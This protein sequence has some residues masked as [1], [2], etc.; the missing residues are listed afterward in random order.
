MA[1]EAPAAG[2]LSIV[3]RKQGFHQGV[4]PLPSPQP[5]PSGLPSPTRCA[6]YEDCD[7]YDSTGCETFVRGD[8]VDNCEPERG[9]CLCPAGSWWDRCWPSKGC[10]DAASL[11]LPLPWL[12]CRWSMRQAVCA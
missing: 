8:D 5:L 12:P 2:H 7:G 11:S 3:P 4:S 6:G 9:W 10:I 1:S